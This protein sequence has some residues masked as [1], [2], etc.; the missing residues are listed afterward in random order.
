[1]MLPSNYTVILRSIHIHIVNA[2]WFQQK[3]W[4]GICWEGDQP[5]F[6]NDE[7][8]DIDLMVQYCN[9]YISH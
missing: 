8:A 1:M 4:Q 9:I 6:E 5:I 3:L 7:V 2:P